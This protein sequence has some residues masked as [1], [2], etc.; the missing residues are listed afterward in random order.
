MAAAPFVG[1]VGELADVA[2]GDDGA[3]GII[4]EAREIL[5]DEIVGF[6]AAG[7]GAAEAVAVAG[8]GESD[9][10]LGLE[11]AGED[12]LELVHGEGGA[13]HVVELGVVGEEIQIARIV[14]IGCAVACDIEDDFIL[15][16]SFGEKSEEGAANVLRSG[17]V[18]QEQADIVF[19]E[20]AAVG[21]EKEIAKF[22]GVAVGELEA[23][24]AAGGVGV[25]GDAD[26]DGEFV[27]GGRAIGSDGGAFVDRGSWSCRRSAG[28]TRRS[29][30]AAWRS[31]KET[32][33][34]LRPGW[35]WKP[36]R[37]PRSSLQRMPS[38]MVVVVM[39]MLA[40]S[41]LILVKIV[42]GLTWLGRLVTWIR[43]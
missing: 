22:L 27:G 31:V 35:R 7:A 41:V 19:G 12:V 9:H 40:A 24:D 5:I 6:F 3:V 15:R 13:A 37:W 39:I 28:E 36:S 43:S 10:A 29:G 4:G 23:G 25:V 32:S 11:D 8:V 14:G 18:V 20:R 21:G 38:D 17:V 34:E 2:G 1:L 16:L 26:D 30:R 33:T 42:P